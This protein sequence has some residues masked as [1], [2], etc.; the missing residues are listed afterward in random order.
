MEDV[1]LTFGDQT[2][3]Y[4]SKVFEEEREGIKSN[5]NDRYQP[6]LFDVWSYS[7]D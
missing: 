5:Q 3:K 2:Y 1:S 4:R 6:L 7:P